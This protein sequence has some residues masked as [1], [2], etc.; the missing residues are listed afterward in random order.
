MSDHDDALLDAVVI[1]LDAEAVEP[2]PGKRLLILRTTRSTLEA[3]KERRV[4]T[5]EAVRTL[6]GGWL[7]EAA[8]DAPEPM[9]SDLESP[10]PKGA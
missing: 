10:G 6:R 9:A 2:D 7:T 3:W 5:E 4:T 1:A 8:D